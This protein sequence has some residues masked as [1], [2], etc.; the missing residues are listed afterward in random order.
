L[1]IDT[2]KKQS[3]K[4]IASSWGGVEQVIGDDSNSGQQQKADKEAWKMLLKQMK[5]ERK[6]K[7]AGQPS[8]SA[9]PASSTPEPTSAPPSSPAS[10]VNPSGHPDEGNSNNKGKPGKN[11]Q[12]KKPK[13]Q[14][15]EDDPKQKL[16]PKSSD[17]EDLKGTLDQNVQN[18]QNVQ[19]DQNDK[20]GKNRDKSNNDG[21]DQPKQTG[22]MHGN[23]FNLIFRHDST[24]STR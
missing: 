2:V 6:D 18:V 15:H 24:S 1:S 3:L 13:E 21:E 20:N 19:N 8:G 16:D 9:P 17:D 4:K 14:I 22:K 23:L 10:T 5:D 7:N 12:N 11:G